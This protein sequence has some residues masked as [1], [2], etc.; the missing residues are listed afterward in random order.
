MK[1]CKIA[2]EEH[3]QNI[4]KIPKIVSKFDPPYFSILRVTKIN[5]KQR[6]LDEAYHRQDHR[7]TTIYDVSLFIIYCGLSIL[8]SMIF[9]APASDSL[10]L[11]PPSM[12]EEATTSK[13]VRRIRNKFGSK[14]L[15][16][17]ATT[18]LTSHIEVG[19]SHNIVYIMCPAYFYYGQPTNTTSRLMRSRLNSFRDKVNSHLCCST[20]TWV[21]RVCWGAMEGWLNPSIHP[22]SPVIHLTLTGDNLVWLASS[23]QI[24]EY[25]PATVVSSRIQ[26]PPESHTHTHILLLQV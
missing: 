18:P 14:C 15:R 6:V 12:D 24:R 2:L 17:K 23:H 8:L 4:S 5:I 13:S 1:C 10:P 26:T 25:P 16:R 11:P 21:R 3:F 7:K 19:H 20:G 9:G 22:N